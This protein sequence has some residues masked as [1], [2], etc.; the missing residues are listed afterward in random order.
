M[1]DNQK[2]SFAWEC[3]WLLCF[4]KNLVIHVHA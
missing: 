2:Y 1:I 4:E 3:E